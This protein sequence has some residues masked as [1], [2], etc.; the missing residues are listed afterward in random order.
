MTIVK[1]TPKELI[2]KR[3]SLIADIKKNWDRIKLFNSVEK[4][5]VRNFDVKKIYEKIIEDS[6]SLIT[7]K[8]AIQ[9][10][11]M[12]LTSVNEIKTN[13]VYVQVYLL[14]QLKEQLVKLA[15]LPT[16]GD[17]VILT[18]QFIQKETKS[19]ETEIAKIEDELEKFNS[20]KKINL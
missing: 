4:G 13:N 14:S 7:I 8:V 5:F 19:I 9:A 12:G 3:E 20:S 16:K 15:K 2:A 6:Q 1:V 10:V 11:N 17:D 18:K